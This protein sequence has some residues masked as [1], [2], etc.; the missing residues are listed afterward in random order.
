MNVTILG[1]G[2]FGTALAVMF[3]ENNCNIKM[4]NK[5]DN[6]F[7]NLKKE[8][9]DVIFTTNIVD[10]IKNTDLIVIAIPLVYLEDCIIELNKYYSNQDILIASKGIDTNSGMFA[11]EIIEKYID[12]KNIGVISGG[13]FAS[14]MKERKV[15]GIT[16]GSKS[17]SIKDKVKRMLE[18]KYLKV[19]YLDDMLGVEI[20]GA[21]KNVMAIGVGILDGANYP[22]SS[23]FLF[24]SEAIYE[25][26]YLI[27]LLGG[28]DNTIM[29]YAG[30]DD[31][32]MTCTS[33]KSRN[34]TMGTLIGL[35]KDKDIIDEY[36]EKTTIEGIG[37]A[38]GVYTLC[39]AKKIHLNIC[40][41][42]YDILYNNCSYKILITYL[43]NKR[44]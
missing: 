26:T 16:L 13:T 28:N 34:Y 32:F 38:L 5:F 31:I 18:N 12:C 1:C 39:K 14:D 43:I 4:W 37:S 44:N 27:K 35:E 42:I 24:L 41:I 3:K 9:N 29:S 6:G 22:E 17:D 36:K 40:N 19:Q 7:D 33:F 11:S 20:C 10:S 30:I 2:A 25:I 21:V 8:L 15:M 23:R